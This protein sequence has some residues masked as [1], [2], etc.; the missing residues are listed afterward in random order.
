MK[1]FFVLIAIIFVTTLGFASPVLAGGDKVFV[2][3]VS[4]FNFDDDQWEGT[5]ISISARA[6]DAHCGHGGRYDHDLSDRRLD[7][8]A[9]LC[10]EEEGKALDKCIKN[11]LVG[12]FCRRTRVDGNGNEGVDHAAVIRLCD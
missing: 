7:A 10:E 3:H 5:I 12:A 6:V 2:C 1:S 11:N 4:S 9:L 8:V